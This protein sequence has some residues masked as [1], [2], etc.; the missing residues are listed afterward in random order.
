[1][2]EYIPII[3]VFEQNG[4]NYVLSWKNGNLPP[5]V[6]Y[7]I[8]DE[9]G[10]IIDGEA[11]TAAPFSLPKLGAGYYRIRLKEA[12]EEQTALLIISPQQAFSGTK[13]KTT[14]LLLCILANMI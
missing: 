10:R 7:E 13:I 2:K 12:D 3:S 9:Y 6:Y 11:S 5:K 1:M 14:D 4:Q 8:E